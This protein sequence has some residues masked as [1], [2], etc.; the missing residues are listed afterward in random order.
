MEFKPILPGNY[1]VYLDLDNKPIK[2]SP[3]VWNVFDTGKV[4]VNLPN[5]D[6]LNG[7]DVHF[8]SKNYLNFIKFYHYN[9]YETF[10]CS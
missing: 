10:F 4:K 3:Y 1:T 6:H 7:Q 8:E 5:G 9:Y 2:G